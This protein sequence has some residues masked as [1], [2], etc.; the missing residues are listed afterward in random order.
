LGTGLLSEVEGQ[1]D[2]RLSEADQGWL[3]GAVVFI[4]D[5][6][7]SMGKHWSPFLLVN[8]GRAEWVRVEAEL[9]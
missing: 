3:D 8:L 1:N 7:G 9:S 4:L 5:C 6:T 2:L